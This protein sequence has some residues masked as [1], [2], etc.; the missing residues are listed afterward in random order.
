MNAENRCPQCGA[1]LAANAP[2]G[3]CPTCL[4]KGALDSQSSATQGGQSAAGSDFVPPTPAEL[5]AH[6]PDLEI[7]ELIGRGGMGMVYKARQ[8]HLDRLVALKILLPKIA[9]DPAFAERFAREARAMAILSHPHIVTVYD[10]GHK[11]T[12]YYFLMEF[13]D[14]ATLRQLLDGGKLASQEALAIVPQICDALQYAHDKGVVHR[15]IKPENIL[16][17]RSGQVKIADFGLAKLVGQ[18]AQGFTITGTGQ[19]MGTPHYMAPEQFEHPLDVDH[20]ADIYSL[21]VVFYQMLTGELP[22]GRFAPPSRKVQVDVR[23]DEVVLRALEKEPELRFQQASEV[24]AEVETIASTPGASSAGLTPNQQAWQSPTMGWGHF[25]GYLFGIT[26]TSP[27]AYHLANLSALGFLA[28]LAFLQYLPFPGSHWFSRLAG[29]SGLFGLIGVAFIVEL[30]VRHKTRGA[31]GSVPPASLADDDAQQQARQLVQGP[32]IGL[33]ITAMLN[34]LVV[35]GI[36]LVMAYKML[37]FGSGTT[38]VVVPLLVAL[39][40]GLACSSFIIFAALKMMRLESYRLAIVA[41]IL[42]IFLLPSNLIGLAIG[43]WS[44]VVLSREDVRRAFA[45]RER[46]KV[47]PRPATPQERRLGIAA[48]A[49]SMAAIP[50]PLMVGISLESRKIVL[51]LFVLMQVIVLICG[52]SGW[53]TV[54]G[55]IAICLSATILFL[56]TTAVAL[57]LMSQLRDEFGGMPALERLGSAPQTSPGKAAAGSVAIEPPEDNAVPKHLTET[58]RVVLELQLQQA[59]AELV[60]MEPVFKAKAISAI[61]FDSAK[62]KVAVLEAELTGDP[63]RVATIQ[64]SIARRELER[65]SALF[66]TNALAAADFEKAK[67]KVAL[68]EAKLHEAEATSKTAANATPERDEAAAAKEEDATKAAKPEQVRQLSAIVQPR[69]QFRLEAAKDDTE[70]ETLALERGSVRV[71]MRV[72]LDESAIAAAEEATTPNGGRAIQLRFTEAGAKKFAELTAA[73]L[74]RRLVILFDGRALVAPMILARIEGP[75]QITGSL[76]EAETRTILG[77]FQSAPPPSPSDI[78]D[79]TSGI[80]LKVAQQQLEKTLNDLQD[81]QTDLA[82]LPAKTDLS[83]AEQE[84]E[85]KKLELKVSV[86]ERQAAR[87]RAL[88]QNR[89]LQR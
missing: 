83:A 10:F 27:L 41:S 45:Q 9:G 26:F 44:L 30:A 40:A 5:A 78:A 70:T 57:L 28:C 43:I 1:E 58:H 75:A 53:R 65:A 66:K 63:V 32:G 2:R 18:E 52:V 35:I 77:I 8:K 72:L 48:L 68:C 15:D 36:A 88:I 82:L 14:G 67:D 29:F 62:D 69:L 20:R 25:V 51:V 13:V 4:L 59:K 16:M 60:R 79:P 6:F 12:L 24:K 86:L 34:G 80:E 49:F 38:I 37:G 71:G 47:P 73:N 21:G 87:L 56:G 39:L 76:S 7:L 84:A 17:D 61:D 89:L 46:N 64:L 11:D 55:R 33:L 22:I 3:L 85:I 74:H 19:V 31:A 42:A 50:V 23:L 81:A 54:V